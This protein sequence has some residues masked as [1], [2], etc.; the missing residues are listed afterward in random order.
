M[1]S[2]CKRIIYSYD[3]TRDLESDS[4]LNAIRSS[5]LT[6]FARTLALRESSRTSKL[7]SPIFLQKTK[8]NFPFNFADSIA[9]IQLFFVLSGIGFTLSAQTTWNYTH[10]ES[11]LITAHSQIDFWCHASRI[12]RSL[13]VSHSS[14]IHVN[15]C[16]VS[17][18]N[19]PNFCILCLFHPK[20]HS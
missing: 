17:V 20:L 5:R 13:A 4:F 3:Q 14:T 7:K 9:S 8:P 19:W 1:M 10:G 18:I 11:E 16:L 12:K 15:S 2:P 6:T